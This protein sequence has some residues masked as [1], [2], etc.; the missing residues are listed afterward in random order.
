[1]S[2][3]QPSGAQISSIESKLKTYQKTVT[4]FHKKFNDLKSAKAMLVKT[5]EEL[6]NELAHLKD[7][8]D[9]ASSRSSQVYI[10]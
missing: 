8:L 3:K 7:E 4:T 10:I 2:F 9:A 6:E 5:R 1:M